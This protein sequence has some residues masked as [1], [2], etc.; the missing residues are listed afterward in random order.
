MKLNTNA[1]YPKAN[2]IM[3]LDCLM[4]SGKTTAM[5]QYFKDNPLKKIVF[6]YPYSLKPTDSLHKSLV[7]NGFNIAS[8]EDLGKG[9]FFEKQAGL[10][11]R[12]VI[13][14][15]LFKLMSP[16]IKAKLIEQ[17]YSIFIDEVLEVLQGFSYDQ[18][19]YQHQR[20]L[21]ENLCIKHGDTTQLKMINSWNANPTDV[22]VV[23]DGFD[24]RLKQLNALSNYGYLHAINNRLVIGLELSFL[25]DVPEVVIATYNFKDSL[26]AKVMKQQGLKYSYVDT[27]ALGLDQHKAYDNLLTNLILC[28][29]Y[30]SFQNMADDSEKLP[31][32]KNWYSSLKPNDWEQLSK[33]LS[34]VMKTELSSSQTKQYFWTCPKSFESKIKW[35][36]KK[37]NYDDLSTWLAFNTKGRNDYQNADMCLSLSGWQLDAERRAMFGADNESAINDTQAKLAMLQWIYRGCIRTQQK[38]KVILLDLRSRTLFDEVITELKSTQH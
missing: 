26:L 14:H 32:S 11:N 27:V 31:F 33:S 3:I 23:T 5:L 10:G 2:N 4:G 34:H 15:T 25:A 8:E 37:S 16:I 29:E 7:S 17:G 36:G 19:S 28:R 35:R 38:Q 24:K 12:V 9:A 20:Y 18:I 22:Y 13:T 6:V 1:L 21:I 30:R